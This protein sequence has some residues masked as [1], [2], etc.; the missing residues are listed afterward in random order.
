[1]NGIEQLKQRHAD[2]WIEATHH[3]FIAQLGDGT[4][5]RAVFRDYFIQDYVFVIDLARFSALAIAKSPGLA[6][7]RPIHAFLSNLL[8]AE[9][10][11]FQTAFDQLDV[12]PEEYHSATANDVIRE[13]SKFLIQVGYEG[14]WPQICTV[15]AVTEGVYLDWGQR[16][17]SEGANPGDELYQGWIDLHT[18]AVLGDFVA[19][20]NGQVGEITEQVE[21]AFLMA[22]EFETNFW[23][24]SFAGG[25]SS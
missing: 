11:L 25:E 19:F 7:A 16:L 5:D 15:L 12:D 2:K 14:T 22:L 13:F 10:A 3:R 1:M 23:N 20:L 4:L 17:A 21:S 24:A 8:G 18:E 9:D 6:E